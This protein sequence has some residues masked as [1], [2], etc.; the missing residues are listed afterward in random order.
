MVLF[1]TLNLGFL[2]LFVSLQF[3]ENERKIFVEYSV[4]R[5]DR[6]ILGVLIADSN[7]STYFF[8][9]DETK[10][11]WNDFMEGNLSNQTK[12][13]EIGFVSIG[14]SEMSSTEFLGNKD[15]VLVKEK[16]PELEWN[17]TQEKKMILGFQCTKAKTKFRCSDYTAWF[18]SDIPISAG[19]WK[20][21]G[22]PGLILE[23]N[24]DTV[25]ENFLS[26][27]LNYPAQ[28]SYNIENFKPNT[29]KIFETFVSYGEAQ[30]IEVKKFKDF[31]RAQ[32]NLPDDADIFIEERECY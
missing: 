15:Y 18:A 23:L 10:N 17:I 24:N 26:T 19:P 32:M 31:L 29:S 21:S 8:Q 30:K 7:S 12:S 20:I 22:L 6:E 3:T 27:K 16:V 11:R 4:T 9:T 5:G 13:I 25:G 14:L 1:K 28:P 2:L